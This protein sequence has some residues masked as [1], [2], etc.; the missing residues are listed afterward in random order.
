VDVYNNRVGKGAFYTIQATLRPHPRAEIEY[1]IDNDHIDSLEPV[2]GSDRILLQRVQQLLAIWHFSPRDSLRAIWQLDS[3]R[4][5]PSLW[6][7]PVSH[8]ERYETVSLTYGHR[9]GINANLYV[10]ATVA[11]SLEPD[12]GVKGYQAEVFVKGSWTFDVL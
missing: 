11:R 6:E 5:A 2:E 3:R 4:R 7:D 9:R 10:G 12:A 8:F 1:R